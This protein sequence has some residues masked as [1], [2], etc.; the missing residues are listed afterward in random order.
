MA[1]SIRAGI[2]GWTYP[3]WR[4]VFYPQG[5]RQADELAYASARLG[6]IEINATYHSLQ[7]PESFA[8][9][10][11][12]T[13]ENFIFTVKAS[14]V[15]TNRR[16]LGDAGEAMERF[17]G[18]GIEKLGARLGPILWQFM[19]TKRYDRAD[20]AAFL[21]LLPAKLGGLT[22]RHCVEVRNASF[23]DPDFVGLCRERGVAICLSE[24]PDYPMIGDVTADFAYARLMKGADDI[25]T[26]YAPADLDAWARRFEAY[27]AGGVPLDPRP[28]DATH[29][30]ARVKRDVFAFF[31]S[32]GK[33]RAPAAAMALAHRLSGP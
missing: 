11:A 13:P 14:R 22:L 28:V 20:F 33:L 27:A 29:A 17:F 18:Q 23:A 30:P 21:S 7:K 26:G 9:W 2:G 8:K 25:E 6:A 1:G 10:A 12:A 5:L 32:A 16:V 3:P 15:C 19:A 31:I 4:G 24:S